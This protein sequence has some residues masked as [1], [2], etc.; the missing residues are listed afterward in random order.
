MKI[1]YLVISSLLAGLISTSAYAEMT[2]IHK[3]KPDTSMDKMVCMKNYLEGLATSIRIDN[4][5]LHATYPDS[6]SH[7][8]AH[9]AFVDAQQKCG[10]W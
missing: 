9:D 5:W 1:N 2:T 10:A 4:H 8:R 7:N 3:A 6:V